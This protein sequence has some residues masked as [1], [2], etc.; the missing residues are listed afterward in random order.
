MKVTLQRSAL[1]NRSSIWVTRLG[2]LAVV[3]G[4][5]LLTPASE[6]LPVELWFYLQHPF[7]RF[8]RLQSQALLGLSR[9]MAM[10]QNRHIRSAEYGQPV[11]ARRRCNPDSSNQLAG[12]T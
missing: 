8:S 7:R 9:G 2:L 6:L 4:V 11:I 5:L 1:P 10:A 12:I 3:L